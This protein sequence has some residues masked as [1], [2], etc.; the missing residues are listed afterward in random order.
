MSE[1]VDTFNAS[2]GLP[3]S[4]PVCGFSDENETNEN[5]NTNIYNSIPSWKSS[6]SYINEQI[7]RLRAQLFELKVTNHIDAKG[8]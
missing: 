2:L 7:R 8:S 1:S 3:T 4:P 6:K 5:C